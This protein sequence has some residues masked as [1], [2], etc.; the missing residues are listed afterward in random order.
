MTDSLRE[1]LVS[2]NVMHN[3]GSGYVTL[4]PSPSMRDR[5]SKVGNS[6]SCLLGKRSKTSAFLAVCCVASVLYMSASFYSVWKPV[7]TN[8]TT[9]PG[10][11]GSGSETANP[12]D[13][14]FLQLHQP[15]FHFQPLQNWKNGK[16]W[17]LTL[18]HLRT[19]P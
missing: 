19:I 10:L 12:H 4:S 11:K 16:H 9:A 3:E 8:T 18:N 7:I 6:E 1:S 13:V 14:E 5:D 17:K 2:V 15:S